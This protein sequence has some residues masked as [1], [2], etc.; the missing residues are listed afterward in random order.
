MGVCLNFAQGILDAVL[1]DTGIRIPY[2]DF[3]S[4]DPVALCYSDAVPESERSKVQKAILRFVRDPQSY[5]EVKP[6]PGA[7][8]AIEQL[9][10]G[11]SIICVS[12]MPSPKWEFRKMMLCNIAQYFPG[13]ADTKFTDQWKLKVVR[14]LA[15]SWVV[16]DSNTIALGLAKARRW[17]L[18]VQQPWNQPPPRSRFILP[19]SSLAA[20]AEYLKQRHFTLKED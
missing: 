6:Y 1:Q 4:P 17:T 5:L 7:C 15:P 18:L 11:F 2:G 16:E 13:I 20:A 10:E 14:G 9:A 3:R 12:R 8:R 19:Q